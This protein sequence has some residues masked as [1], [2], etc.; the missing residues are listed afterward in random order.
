MTE[1]KLQIRYILPLWFVMLVTSFLPDNKFIFKFRGYLC[2][3]FFK[4]CGK[5]LQVG[6][7]VTILNS[8]NMSI[9]DNVYITKGVWINALGGINLNDEV[10]IAPYVTISTLQHVFKN[11]SCRFGG[12]IVGEVKIGKGTWIA[13]NSSIK[14]GVDIGSGS[15]VAANSFV[16]K[17]LL[18][19]SIYGGVPAKFI[20][21][22]NEIEAS[23]FSKIDILK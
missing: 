1:F 17:N 19:N 3:S 6:R 8:F 5:N 12:S 16:S 2:K 20:K 7:D 14:C 13:A 23:I 4:N 11:K 21:K 22:N 15:I 9:G 18:D 10:M